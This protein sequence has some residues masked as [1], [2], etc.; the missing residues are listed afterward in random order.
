MLDS[1]IVVNY[2]LLPLAQIFKLAVLLAFNFAVVLAE[3]LCAEV[4]AV[5]VEHTD[6][7]LGK[8]RQIQHFEAASH[9]SDLITVVPQL[10]AELNDAGLRHINSFMIFVLNVSK[11]NNAT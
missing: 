9:F 1:P 3:S 10:F 2:F 8:K 4:D 11:C 7:H 6:P 5:I